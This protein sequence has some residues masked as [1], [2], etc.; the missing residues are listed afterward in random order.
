MNDEAKVDDQEDWEKV[1]EKLLDALK[2]L[3]HWK[4]TSPNGNSRGSRECSVTITKV[5]EA[6]LW[7]QAEGGFLTSV[8]NNSRT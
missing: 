6:I 7:W 1:N 2:E 3:E 8:R 4:E 5:E